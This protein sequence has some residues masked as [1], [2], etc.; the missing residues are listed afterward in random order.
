M[1]PFAADQS[2]FAARA[3]ILKEAEGSCFAPV[4]TGCQTAAL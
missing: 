3:T 2:R 4:H 1:L